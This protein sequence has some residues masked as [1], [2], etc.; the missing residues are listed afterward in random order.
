MESDSVLRPRCR[1]IPPG[2]CPRGNESLDS[3]LPASRVQNAPVKLD[4]L[5]SHPSRR[6]PTCCSSATVRRTRNWPPRSPIRSPRDFLHTYNIR[7]AASAGLS[8]FMEKQLEELKAQMERSS[9]ALAEFERDLSVINPD[10]K[11]SILSSRLL[12]IN[13]TFTCPGRSS[14][15][16]P[17]MTR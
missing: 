14:A 1:A 7:F 10:E 4:R 11:T 6:I 2:N 12:Q 16:R 15:S 8:T 17:P 5:K 13:T 3:K 9:A